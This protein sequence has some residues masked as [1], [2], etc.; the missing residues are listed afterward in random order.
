MNPDKIKNIVEAALLA[1]GRPLGLD[2]LQALF[3][4]DGPAPSR[5]VLKDAL[6]QLGEDYRDRALEVK[7]V[8]SGYRI[9]VTTDYAQWMNRLWTER[10]ARYSRALL[11]TLALVAYRQPIT[12]GEIEDVRGVAV[13]SNIIRTLLER[14]WIKVVGHRDVPGKPAMY[15]TTR[16]FLDYFNLKTLGELP[17]LQEI[18]DIDAI[19]GDL[20]AEGGDGGALTAR[21]ALPDDIFVPDIDTDD[22]DFDQDPPA[23]SDSGSEPATAPDA[24][25]DVAPDPASAED[26]VTA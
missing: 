26:P 24:G 9:Q 17:T 7:Q 25:A 8:A 1:A 23:G 21:A 12:R 4:D 15:G 2:A 5:E 22:V 11:E 16:E 14:E 19:T 6:Q 18:R 13:S 3:E 20:F 10:P